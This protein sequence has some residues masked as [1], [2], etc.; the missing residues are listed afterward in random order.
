MI[1]ILIASFVVVCALVTMA[2]AVR[3]MRQERRNLDQQILEDIEADVFPEWLY[4]RRMDVPGKYP[5]RRTRRT[6]VL[7]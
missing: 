7:G 3:V 5:A 6:K 4:G 2:L 1:S